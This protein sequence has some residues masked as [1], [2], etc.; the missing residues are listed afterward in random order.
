[1][2]DHHNI[3]TGRQSVEIGIGGGD[4]CAGKT[5]DTGGPDRDIIF[6][7]GEDDYIIHSYGG[8]DWII[9]GRGDDCIYGGAGA[10]ELSGD[11]GDD[12]IYGEE[13]ADKLYGG[14]GADKLYGGPGNDFISG[15]YSWQDPGDDYLTGGAGDDYLTGGP[16]ADKLYGD[17]GD[18]QL[19]GGAGDDRLKGGPGDDLLDGDSID[20]AGADIFM[21][22]PGDSTAG[23]GDVILDFDPD[24]GDR[25]EL[26][27]FSSERPTL[28][29]VLDASGTL[30]V[31]GANNNYYEYTYGDG[32]EDDRIITLPDGGKITLLNVGDAEFTIDDI[33]D[34]Q[35]GQ[36]GDDQQADLSSP[37]IHSGTWVTKLLGAPDDV[38][39]G[40]PGPSFLNGG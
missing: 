9:G 19:R 2:T 23:G 22:S 12:H 29:D 38:L 1:M 6:K 40:G 24:E 17:S 28:S 10:D 39:Q 18:D 33:I 34:Q 7:F 32:R 30:T 4:P 35:A 14:P 25:I 11:P 21:F 3:F 13:G 5:P 31:G 27:G 20:G 26:I 15:T 8:N 37:I 16:G 36:A